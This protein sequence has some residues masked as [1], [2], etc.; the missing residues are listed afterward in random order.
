[1]PSPFAVHAPAQPRVGHELH[2]A[3]RAG[4]A[5]AH[6]AAEVRLDLVDRSEHLP[7]DPVGRAGAEPERVQLVVG[8]LA[9]RAGTARRRHAGGSSSE[10]GSFGVSALGSATGTTGDVT[11]GAS[12]TTRERVGGGA[13]AR[14]A[15]ARAR[16]TAAAERAH[17]AL[18]RT[19]DAQRGNVLFLRR[20][21]VRGRSLASSASCCLSAWSSATRKS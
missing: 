18:G 10:P 5:R 16:A 1:M 6:V 8:Q 11:T 13:A 9:R 19:D 21:L 20:G 2:P 3:D 4:R 14:R 7:R 17:Q 15:R 12:G